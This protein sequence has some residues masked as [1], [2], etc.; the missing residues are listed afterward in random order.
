MPPM[1]PCRTSEVL[2]LPESFRDL[3]EC[4]K[5]HSMCHSIQNALPA[6]KLDGS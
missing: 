4:H 1:V 5:R 6:E 3:P 2:K